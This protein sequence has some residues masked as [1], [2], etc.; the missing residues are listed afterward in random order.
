MGDV[1]TK[2][3]QQRR[4]S[5]RDVTRDLEMAIGAG[6]CILKKGTHEPSSDPDLENGNIVDQTDITGQT[7][8]TELT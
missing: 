8:D 4:S 5:K 2:H 7:W 1:H 6:M 3:N